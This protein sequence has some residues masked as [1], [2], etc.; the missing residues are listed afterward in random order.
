MIVQEQNRLETVASGLITEIQGQMK[1]ILAQTAIDL[2]ALGYDYF[3]GRGFVNAS[4]AV[5]GHRLSTRFCLCPA[6]LVRL[7]DKLA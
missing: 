7:I 5:L 6:D 1:Q 3:T 4:A 2:D